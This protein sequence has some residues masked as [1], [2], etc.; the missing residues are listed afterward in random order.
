MT[1][2]YPRWKRWEYQLRTYPLAWTF[3]VVFAVAAFVG[4]AWAVG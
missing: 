2:P 1:V 4:W 3:V